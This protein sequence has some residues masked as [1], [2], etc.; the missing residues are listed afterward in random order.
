[1]E[2]LVTA[3]GLELNLMDKRGKTPLY[4]AMNQTIRALLLEKGAQ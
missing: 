2:I 3:P 4:Y 1:V